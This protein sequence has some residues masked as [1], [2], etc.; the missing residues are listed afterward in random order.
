MTA[1]WRSRCRER[2]GRS[3]VV[4]WHDETTPDATLLTLRILG[5]RLSSQAVQ[6]DLCVGDTNGEHRRMTHEQR[7]A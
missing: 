4:R 5:A 6:S 1:S 7:H 2:L 3:V